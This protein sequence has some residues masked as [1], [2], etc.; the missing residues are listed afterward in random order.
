MLVR[1]FPCRTV[2]DFEVRMQLLSWSPFIGKMTRK[3]DLLLNTEHRKV[4]RTSGKLERDCRDITE[5]RLL[6]LLNNSTSKEV[7]SFAG[8]LDLKP[9]GTKLDVIMQVKHAISKDDA[10][11]K[12][13]FK[14]L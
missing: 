4:D 13:M 8:T 12:K 1:G 3:N 7:S 6:E 10:K 14:Q 5:E 9:K 2:P 11:F